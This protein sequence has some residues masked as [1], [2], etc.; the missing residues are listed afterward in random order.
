METPRYAHV[1]GWLSRLL[2]GTKD[3]SPKVSPTKPRT[4]TIKRPGG[5]VE[6]KII[7]DDGRSFDDWVADMD[8]KSKA[9]SSE[10]RIKVSRLEAESLQVRDL[11]QLTSK[12]VRIVGSSNWVIDAER[13]KYGGSEYLLVRE[14]KNEYDPNAVAV[15]GKGRK[16]GYVSAAKAASFAPI[17]DSLPEDAFLVSGTSTVE[18]SLR[19]WVDL[20]S[21]PAL[22]KMGA[23]DP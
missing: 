22:R 3:A 10:P 16:V 11:R 19:L 6:T 17:L 1:M 23:G 8:A 14:P 20:P 13:S 5:V 21:V 2:G 12:R 4:V 9:R 18:G 7:E 15:Y